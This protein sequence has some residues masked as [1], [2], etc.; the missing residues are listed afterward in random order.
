LRRFIEFSRAASCRQGANSRRF[1]RGGPEGPAS[2]ITAITV[3]RQK[4]E[5]QMRNDKKK[6]KERGPLRPWLVDVV[7][8][9]QK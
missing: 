7:V 9:I 5:A 4:E 3:S 8:D 6:D 2:W 1:G